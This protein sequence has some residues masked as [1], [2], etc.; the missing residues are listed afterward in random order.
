MIGQS[1]GRAL[2]AV[3]AAVALVATQLVVPASA[4]GDPG[5]VFSSPVAADG[6]TAWPGDPD[7]TPEHA[8]SSRLGVPCWQTS[9]D[10]KDQ[11][12]YL[13]VDAARI[14][15]GATDAVLTVNY[16]DAPGQQLSAQYD[17]VSAAFTPLPWF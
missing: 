3:T 13:N 8:A 6:I 9:N 1:L 5:I 4:V 10:L 11:Y 14:P 17:S 15:A 7:K 12:I 16:F 2:A